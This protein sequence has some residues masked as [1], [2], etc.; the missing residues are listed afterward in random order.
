MPLLIQIDFNYPKYSTMHTFTNATLADH[1]AILPTKE[2][3]SF[4]VQILAPKVKTIPVENQFR[5]SLF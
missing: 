2:K 3:Q 4:M 1:F 5:F